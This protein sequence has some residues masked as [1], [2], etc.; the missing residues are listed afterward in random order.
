MPLVV[1]LPPQTDT[2]HKALMHAVRRDGGVTST[3]R[4]NLSD[5]EKRDSNADTDENKAVDCGTTETGKLNS[6]NACTTHS[7]RPLSLSTSCCWLPAEL[8]PMRRSS[9]RITADFTCWYAA[10]VAKTGS[11][12]ARCL[13]LAASHELFGYVN[14]GGSTHS[15]P[16]MTASL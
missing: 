11:I 4:E 3:I 2:G 12:N 8:L 9:A 1:D 15:L 14:S 16:F 6:M 7:T 10:P 5:S 13:V